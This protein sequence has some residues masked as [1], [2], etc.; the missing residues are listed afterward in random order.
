MQSLQER[1][2]NGKTIFLAIAIISIG[3]VMT[4]SVVASEFL[5]PLLKS[6]NKFYLET[7]LPLVITLIAVLLLVGVGMLYSVQR[8]TT[9]Y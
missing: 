9:L 6:E 8:V 7:T 5:E 4:M 2:G 1:N 3:F